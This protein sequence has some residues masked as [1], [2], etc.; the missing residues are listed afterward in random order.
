M[1]RTYS[2]RVVKKRSTVHRT[3]K[4][5]FCGLLIMVLAVA[6]VASSA[7]F[8]A[9]RDVGLQFESGEVLPDH[10]YYA[11]GPD[12]K[13]NALIA[14]HQS[15]ELESPYWRPIEV[16]PASLKEL[17]ATVKFVLE[18]EYKTTPNGA[19]IVTR[20]GQTVGVWYSVYDQPP[21]KMVAANQVYLGDPVPR[22]PMEIRRKINRRD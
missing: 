22:L 9:S 7:Y 18:G 20:D 1:L 6:C 16:T 4:L 8:S 10:R 12:R 3:D 2:N 19:R 15:Y 5:I 13:P 14:I 11:G 17:T 21:V